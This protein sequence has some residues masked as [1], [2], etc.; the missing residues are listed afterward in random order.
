VQQQHV[1]AMMEDRLGARYMRLDA[2]WP[3]GAGL[4]ID[5]ATAK[6]AKTLTMLAA[7]TVRELDRKRLNFFLGARS[8]GSTA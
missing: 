1:Q 4:G 3:T 6:A 7:R 8:P 5:I 2:D